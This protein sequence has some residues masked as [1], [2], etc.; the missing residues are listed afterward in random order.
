MAHKILGREGECCSLVECTGEELL[1]APA[2][3]SVRSMLDCGFE[4]VL[5][6]KKER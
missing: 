6:M 5:D 1:L 2:W 4:G 3:T